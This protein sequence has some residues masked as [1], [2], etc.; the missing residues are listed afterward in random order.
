M[1]GL[2]GTAKYRFQKIVSPSKLVIIV[3]QRLIQNYCFEYLSHF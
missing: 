1:N 3:A 2:K